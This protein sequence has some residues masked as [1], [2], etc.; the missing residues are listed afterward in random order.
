MPEETS[1]HLLLGAQHQ[2][3]GAEQDYLPYGSTGT[4]SGHCQETNTCMVWAC[5]TPRHVS[6]RRRGRQRKCW[7]DNFRKVDIPAHARTAHN[8]HLQKRQEGDLCWIV[9]HVP[10]T[11]QSVKGLNVT[12]LFWLSLYFNRSSVTESS[13]VRS[14]PSPPQWGTAD[15][16]I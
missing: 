9:P 7:M 12:E 16:E 1:P 13:T 5:H 10:T 4:S 8:S 15:A 6:G 11:I 14:L 2:R 3:L